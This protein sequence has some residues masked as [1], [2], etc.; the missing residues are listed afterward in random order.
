LALKAD[1]TV[2]A[3]FILIPDS[4]ASKVMNMAMRA[5]A[6]SGVKRLRRLEFATQSTIDIMRAEM[7]NS[8]AKAVPTPLGPGI[9][10]T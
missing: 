4:G 10:T 6:K 2:R 1:P 7:M 9:V 5:P 8:A 3:G